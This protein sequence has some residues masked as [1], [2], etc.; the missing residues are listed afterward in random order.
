MEKDK[1]ASNL[2]DIFGIENE[3]KE[4]FYLQ[5]EKF[6][7]GFKEIADHA[8]R[9]MRIGEYYIGIRNY[10]I[11]KDDFERAENLY[12]SIDYARGVAL[13]KEKQAICYLKTKPSLSHTAEVIA[14]HAL[15][16]FK[17]IDDPESVMRLK[18]L[19]KEIEKKCVESARKRR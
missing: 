9:H 4:H 19:I 6:S 2:A 7:K 5:V 3:M 12:E 11:A 1:K 13:S 16:I 10:S 15:K 17:E 14:K 8:A 18:M